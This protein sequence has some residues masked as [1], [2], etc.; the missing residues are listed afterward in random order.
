MSLRIGRLLIL[1]GAGAAVSAAE[2]EQLSVAPIQDNTLIEDDANLSNGAGPNLFIGTIASGGRR[3]SLLKFDLSAIPAGS[4][5][6]SVTLRFAVNRAAVGSGLADAASLHRATAGWGEG[7]SD[8]T[9]GGGDSATPLDATWLHRF[10][11]G[12][13]VPQLFWSAPGGDYVPL[14]SST[15]AIAGIGSYVFPTTPQLVTDVQSWINAPSEN[16][17]WVMRGPEVGSQNARRIHS[18]ESSSPS[19]RPMLTISYTPA[20][21]P[22]DG[23]DVPL[24]LWSIVL[25]GSLLLGA[26]GKRGFDKRS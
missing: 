25:L 3:R 15:I 22:S 18:R 6:S 1:A 26:V 9:R 8:A 7:D 10:H 2:A 14:A 17:G 12:S 5:V 19:D 13:G 4:Q 16:F 21:S 20:L 23:G 24:P 11:G